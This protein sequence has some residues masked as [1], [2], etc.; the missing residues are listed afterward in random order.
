MND[1][2]LCFVIP[3]FNHVQFMETLLGQLAIY[4]RQCI[5][6]N[7]GSDNVSSNRLHDVVSQ[8]DGVSLVSHDRNK[9]KGAAV[10][11]GLRQ[12]DSLGFTHALQIDADGQ[13]DIKDVQSF[14]DTA[15][16]HKDSLIAGVPVYDVTVPKG[17]LYGRYITHIWVWINT[18]SFKIR[19]SM[20]GFRVYP[21]AAVIP[22]INSARIGQRMDFDTEIIVRLSWRGV[23]IVNKETKVIYPDD[24]VS[25][26]KLVK[27]NVLISLMHARL[28]VGMIVRSPLLISRHFI[29]Q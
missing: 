21:L 15:A 22:I 20:C 23:D 8:F 7:D 19:D 6:V 14:I 29:R 26:F 24:G 16:D 13:H 1:F 27:D 9:G 11:T 3:V 10:I 5:V 2:R 18:L 12:A 25:N 28:F 4:N 17:R